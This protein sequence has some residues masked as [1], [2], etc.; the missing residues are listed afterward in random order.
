MV[1]A[2][3]SGANNVPQARHVQVVRPHSRSKAGARRQNHVTHS[4]HTGPPARPLNHVQLCHGLLNSH[5]HRHRAT[6][7]AKSGE[8]PC[9]VPVPLCVNQ[10]NET[11][12]GFGHEAPNPAVPAPMLGEKPTYCRPR[13]RHAQ[14][15]LA[16]PRPGAI[17]PRQRIADRLA[18]TQLRGA[19]P[20]GLAPSASWFFYQLLYQ[21]PP[22]HHRPP[23][24]PGP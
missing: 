11:L 24:Q 5:A 21:Y 15:L 9:A 22:F 19:N 3:G 13:S 8:Q 7:P 4:G 2:V 12:G 20:V 10:I 1:R 14:T 16:T 23:Y 17:K 18:G 6:G